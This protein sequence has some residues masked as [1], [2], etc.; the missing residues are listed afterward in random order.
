MWRG[1]LRSAAFLALYLLCEVAGLLAAAALWLA[2]PLLRFDAARWRE[3]HFRLQDAWGAA[4]FHGMRRCFSLRIELEGEREARLGE[5]PYL[6]LVRHASSGDTLLASALIGRT[7][8]MRLR[9]VLKRE[10]LWDPCLRVVGTRLGHLFVDRSADDPTREI[11]RVHA[12]GRALGPREGV[13]IYPE[14]TRFSAAKRARILA[15]LA[16]E[17]DLKRLDYA[18]SLASVLPPRS[19]GVLALL[20]AAPEADVVVC[21]HRGFEGA[22]SLADL[23]RGALLGARVRVRF[24]RIPRARIP[25]TRGAR[26]LWLGELWQQVDDWVAS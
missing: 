10:L 19:G 11:A 14:G 2:R 3:L 21:M 16:R 8:G 9:Y 20:D 1:A 12:L 25:A 13:L 23:R 18:S 24:L 15:R 17:G 5:G 4:L 26:A 6:L 22:G 7:Y